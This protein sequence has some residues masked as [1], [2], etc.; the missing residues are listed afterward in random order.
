MYESLNLTV[1]LQSFQKLLAPNKQTCIFKLPIFQI[2]AS[3]VDKYCSHT[4]GQFFT[5]QISSKSYIFPTIIKVYD[6]LKRKMLHEQPLQDLFRD[7][8]HVT[9]TQTLLLI[10][11][12]INL[13]LNHIK[14]GFSSSKA[15]HLVIYCEVQL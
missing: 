5:A 4:T 7:F 9:Q 8:T 2:A 12:D 3:I 14:N 15:I 1:I 6:R 11:I 10:I 13:A